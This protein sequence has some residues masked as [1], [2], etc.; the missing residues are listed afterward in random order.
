MGGKSIRPEALIGL[1][2][3]GALKNA[4]MCR[5]ISGTYTADNYT[6]L[7]HDRFSEVSGNV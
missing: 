3:I 1:E 5:W 2:S 4:D 6:S 7:A